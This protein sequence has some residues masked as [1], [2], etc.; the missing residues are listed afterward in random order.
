MDDDLKHLMQDE[1]LAKLSMAISV[2]LADYKGPNELLRRA[3]GEPTFL[4]DTNY[5][6]DWLDAGEPDD[7]LIEM[8]HQRLVRDGVM[9]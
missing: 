1:K 8:V 7:P 3:N 4:E 6:F 2:Q 9:T 5:W